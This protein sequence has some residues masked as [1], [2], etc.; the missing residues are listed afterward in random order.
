MSLWVCNSRR[1]ESHDFPLHKIYH[2]SCG[3][4]TECFDLC[5]PNISMFLITELLY[6]YMPIKEKA[7]ALKILL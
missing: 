4:N 6:I 5:H 1:F 2:P 3:T 7:L